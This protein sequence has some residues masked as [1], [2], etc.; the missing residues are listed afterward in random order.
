M[1]I[2]NII[3]TGIAMTYHKEDGI[4]K[5]LF[6]F[7]E[8]HEVKFK[9][10]EAASGIPLA[11][12]NRQIRITTEDAVSKFEIGKNY[13][14]FLD[15]TA[16]YSHTNG[17]TLKNDWEQKAVLMSIEDAKLSVHEYTKTEHL[18]LK[19]NEV[20]FA[21]ALIG[22]SAKATI[23]S[24]RVILEV[25]DHLDFP[26]VFEEDCTLIFD[27]DCQL[28]DIREVSDF[29]MV[30]NVVEPIISEEER[31]IVSKLPANI[32]YPV[33]VGTL[34][35]LPDLND[36]KDPFVGGLPCHLVAVSQPDNLP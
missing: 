19:A 6:P 17:V 29:D 36:I 1:A 35:D 5:V 14:S 26:K 4:W 25:D 28:G 20:T 15:L 24:E 3:I 22:Y 30:Y 32:D 33:T 31:F 7:G 16:D 23:N 27:N 18:M 21:P 10:N 11:A 13:S 34:L 8:C 12:A 9:E 2:V